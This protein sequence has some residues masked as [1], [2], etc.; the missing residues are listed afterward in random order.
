[1][2][3]ERQWEQYPE[4]DLAPKQD[5]PRYM[6]RS[7]RG[8]TDEGGWRDGRFAE[9]P[10]LGYDDPFILGWYGSP[11]GM[12]YPGR[13]YRGRPDDRGGKQRDFWDRASDEISSWFGDEDAERRRWRDEHRGKGPKGYRRSDDRIFEDVCDRLM[14]DGSIDAG[15]I[16]VSVSE[17]E[18]TLTG[19]VSDRYEKRR[20]EDCA[21]S[22]S[23]VQHTQNN[24]RIRYPETD[25]RP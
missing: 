15:D 5:D 13:Y 24:L 7:R 2:A 4:H 8:W 12:N 11:I 19:A 3:Y 6:G 23:G 9:R 25:Q 21:D 18:V 22:V 14:E 10:P 17:N 1:M 16:E 20:A